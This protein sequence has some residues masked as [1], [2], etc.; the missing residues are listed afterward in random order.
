MD[1]AVAAPLGDGTFV[2]L[3]QLTAARQAESD[4]FYADTP[5][6]PVWQLLAH[7]PLDRLTGAAP[8]VY[9]IVWIADDVD[10][11]DGDPLHDSNGVLMLHAEALGLRGARRRVEVTVARESQAEATVPS[12]DGDPATR[13]E[14]G[15][16]SWRVQ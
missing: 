11:A 4:A 12:P 2:P 5:D 15:I 7:A 1:G 13:S 6:R 9:V 3:A 14:V 10:E 16:V 8:P